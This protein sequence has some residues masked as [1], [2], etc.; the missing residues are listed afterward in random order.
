MYDL[1]TGILRMMDEFRDDEREIELIYRIDTQLE[2]LKEQYQLEKLIGNGDDL[3][4]IVALLQWEAAH[5]FHKGN[6]DNHVKNTAMDLFDYSFDKGIEHGIN[7]RSLSIALMEC[8][9]AVGIKARVVYLMPFSPYDGDN[10]VVC[11][12]WSKELNKWI[13]V[14]PTY[15]LYLMDEDNIPLSIIEI[16]EKLAYRK[17]LILSN[18]YHYNGVSKDKSNIIEYYAKDFFYFHINKIQGYDIEFIEDN[19]MLTIAPNGY[20]VKKSKLENINY[21]IEK[22]GDNED[23][24]NWRKDVTSDVLIYKGTQILK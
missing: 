7:C 23:M 2:L 21:R 8:Y 5:I 11:E 10:H 3:T 20:D 14:D 19:W 18:G 16:R 1:Y 9:L 6:Y 15:A 13:M 17:E 22:W 4:K 12:A 24:Q